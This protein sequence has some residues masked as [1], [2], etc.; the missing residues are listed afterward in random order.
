MSSLATSP[1]ISASAGLDPADRA[2]LN[3]WVNR[4]FD[5]ER[6]ARL[7]GLSPEALH[8]RRDRIVERLSADL[9]LP[10]DDVRTS[11][12]E[13]AAAVA[14]PAPAPGNGHGAGPAAEHGPAPPVRAGPDLGPAALHEEASAT[15]APGLLPGPAVLHSPVTAPAAP[16]AANAPA[17]GITAAPPPDTATPPEPEPRR[18]RRR[19]WM[20]TAVV[21]AAA[22]AV[23]VVALA[24]DGSTPRAARRPARSP[25]G[26]S[27]SG[28]SA[29]ARTSSAA[30][31][32]T[33]APAASTAS[34]ASTAAPATSTAFNASSAPTAAPAAPAPAPAPSRTAALAGLPG[35]LTGAH[36]TVQLLG[37][38]PFLK[39]KLTVSSLPSVRSGH[40]EVWLYNSIID[41]MPLGRL[42]AGS[43]AAVF[44]LP[45]RAPHFRWIDIS[46]QPPGSV[47]HS[48]ESQLRAPDPA[49]GVRAG[50]GVSRRARQVRRATRGSKRASTSK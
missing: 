19:L 32:S 48:G 37:S 33:A 11:L 2:L 28:V 14:A 12:S 25:A 36:G 43:H 49:K 29:R 47:N 40:Y 7:T 5:D 18:P 3:L 34:S 41:S 20:A 22:V 38:A 17:P 39:L 15:V 31:A 44:G 9:G 13:I 45:S 10:A 35:G 1:L 21:A 4:G 24:S 6:L 46:L 23:I 50:P 42:A 30:S 26:G 27:A 8:R 16:D